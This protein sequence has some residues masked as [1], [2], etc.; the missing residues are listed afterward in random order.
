MNLTSDISNI[1][2]YNSVIYKY[3]NRSATHQGPFVP[4]IFTSNYG[5]KSIKYQILNMKCKYVAPLLLLLLLLSLLF[6]HF[7]LNNFAPFN[8]HY[9]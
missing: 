3:S 2:D 9:N 1:F 4:E 8:L 6:D 5:T 7:S